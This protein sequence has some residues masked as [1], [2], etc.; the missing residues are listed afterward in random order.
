MSRL[1]VSSVHCQTRWSTELLSS[2]NLV[3]QPTC[4]QLS[5]TFCFNG[6]PT[7]TVVEAADSVEQKTLAWY[8]RGAHSYLMDN[9]K[10]V[11]TI[12][13]PFVW[14]GVIIVYQVSLPI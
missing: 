7:A 10:V 6:V 4:L 8:R 11:E 5:Q 9:K 2:W 1:E 3:W 14:G 12:D 13:H